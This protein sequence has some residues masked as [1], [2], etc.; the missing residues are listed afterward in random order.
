MVF[1]DGELV[2]QEWVAT[3]AVDAVSFT[4]SDGASVGRLQ[5]GAAAGAVKVQLELGGK[6][7][8]IVAPDADI[9]RAADLI[10]RGA[11]ASAGQ[12]CTSTASVICVG[13]ASTP[14]ATPSSIASG[15]CVSVTR[16]IRRRPC[17]PLIDGAARDRVAGMVAD[18]E[19]A[20]RTG[21]H[22][23]RTCRGDGAFHPPIVLDG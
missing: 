8:V 22:R 15:R 1:A 3:G 20:G 9:G 17:G 2:E 11:M 21:A 13:S 10:V 19:A 5:G 16:S 4:G 6:N 23:G 18:A 7:S 12:K 14:S